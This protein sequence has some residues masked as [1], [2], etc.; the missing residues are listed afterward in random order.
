MAMREACTVRT[1]ERQLTRARR[2]MR[3]RSAA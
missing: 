2:T 3:L 1:V